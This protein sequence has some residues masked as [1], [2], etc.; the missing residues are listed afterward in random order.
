MSVLAD[1]RIIIDK[2]LGIFK[3]IKVLWTGPIW[4]LG[5]INIFKKT[6]KLTEVVITPKVGIIEKIKNVIKPRAKLTYWLADEEVIVYVST[7]HQKDKFKLVY[8]EIETGR[9]VM[10]NSS[11]PINYR[12]EELKAGDSIQTTEIQQNQRY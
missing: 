8:T 12:L 1:L 4:L 6:I 3:C 7:F 11:Q 2:T 10:V 9:Q 5:K